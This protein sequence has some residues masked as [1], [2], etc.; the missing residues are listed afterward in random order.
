MSR[1]TKKKVAPK[2]VAQKKNSSKPVKQEKTKAKT[3]QDVFSQNFNVEED[4]EDEED[5]SMNYTQNDDSDEEVPD[6]RS[7]YGL[8]MRS[9]ALDE[10]LSTGK[11]SGASVSRKDLVD[12][13]DGSAFRDMMK[14]DKQYALE[15][16]KVRDLID[17]SGPIE[18]A[19]DSEDD[20]GDIDI[21]INELEEDN[22]YESLFIILTQ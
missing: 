14:D 20:G 8:A 2:K 6:M 1:T 12:E 15:L 18:E 7:S 5:F 16:Q 22:K 21:H 17:Q 11:Y 3:I 10:E 4:P 19:S 9:A 13:D